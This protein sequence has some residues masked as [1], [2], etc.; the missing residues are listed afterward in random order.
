M[1]TIVAIAIATNAMTATR[2][3]DSVGFAG[4]AVAIG[5]GASCPSRV[6]DL[7]G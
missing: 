2:P 4:T 7:G 6:P 5:R 3:G 1:I